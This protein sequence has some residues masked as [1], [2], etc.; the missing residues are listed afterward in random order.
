MI[1]DSAIFPPV[2]YFALLENFNNAL[3][4][5]NS[6]YERQ[7]YR[8]RYII[9]GANGE[10]SLSIPVIKPNGSKAK[11]KD[12]LVSYDTPWN[13]IHWKSIVSAYN[14]S[15]FFQYYN[16]EIENIFN[17]KWKY[18]IDLNLES[19]NTIS[20]NLGLHI[21]LSLTEEFRPN[22]EYSDDFRGVIHPKRD[23]LADHIFTPLPYRQVF[24][25][26]NGFIQNL[27]ILDL[28]FNKGP[29]SVLVLKNSINI[30]KKQ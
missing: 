7:S 10:L 25:Q 1:L 3:I 21:N 8:N 29:G 9:A 2:S 11:M 4:E 28:L 12:V 5:C 30:R 18:L 6:N 15:P 16:I 14:S 13:S 17:K 22:G 23:S 24:D 27:S 19:V 26:K 20:E